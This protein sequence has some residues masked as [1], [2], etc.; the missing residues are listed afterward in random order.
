[1]GA[2]YALRVYR[3]K[4]G[5]FPEGWETVKPGDL[6]RITGRLEHPQAAGDSRVSSITNVVQRGA[7]IKRHAYRPGGSADPGRG[8]PGYS[9]ADSARGS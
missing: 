2:K 5:S 4:S 9:L 6:I 3:D 7:G 1:V 8:E